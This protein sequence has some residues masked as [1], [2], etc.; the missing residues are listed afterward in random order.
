MDQD[1][2]LQIGRVFFEFHFRLNQR[3]YKAVAVFY[4]YLF[5]NHIFSALLQ[6]N[7]L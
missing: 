3:L 6:K 2:A 7:D 1:Q 5:V 4:K